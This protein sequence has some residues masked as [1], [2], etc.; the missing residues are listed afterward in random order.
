MFMYSCDL[1]FLLMLL[2]EQNISIK[3]KGKGGWSIYGC[4]AETQASCR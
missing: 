4:E 1:S 3:K 2:S